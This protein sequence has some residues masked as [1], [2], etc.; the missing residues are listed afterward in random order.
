LAA[1]KLVS[2]G[3]EN[4]MSLNDD[5]KGGIYLGPDGLSIGTG[6]K[7]E[8]GGGASFSNSIRDDLR[9]FS[10]VA[11]VDR[12]NSFTEEQWATYGT[13]GHEETWSNTSTTRNGCRVGDMFTVTG[14]ATDSG[15]A[16]VLYYRSTTAV[17]DLHGTCVSHSI[18]ERG[19]AV[20]STTKYYK[21]STEN[22]ANDGDQPNILEPI[23]SASEERNRGWNKSPATFPVGSTSH[24]Y[25]ESVRSLYADGSFEWSVPVKNSMLTVDF[26]NSLGI[27]AKHIEVT[28][29]SG[30]PIFKAAGLEGG[31]TVDIAGFTV[32][33]TLLYQGEDI[34]PTRTEDTE[35]QPNS[36]YI[37]TSNIKGKL[38]G[39]NGLKADD[40][41]LTVGN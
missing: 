40:W 25:Y 32:K 23:D 3:F 10:I 29:V 7:I 9:G 38:G 11:N 26:I 35:F 21:L 19:V 15:K 14:T 41:R 33:S 13:T 5:N 17:D 6:F 8:A 1:V 24:N 39:E 27:T 20:S 16:H 22:L 34:T 2:G 4:K 18:S 30:V 28:N 36:V 37:G 12:S 31:G